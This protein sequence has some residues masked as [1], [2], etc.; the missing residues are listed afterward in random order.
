MAPF[1]KEWPYDPNRFRF[2][3][4]PIDG[5]QFTDDAVILVEIKTGKARLT[6]GQKAIQNLVKEGKVKFATF[7]V[8][9]DGVTLIIEENV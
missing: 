8:G 9:E 7:R 6:T 1:F 5:V 3:G 4:S 2:M